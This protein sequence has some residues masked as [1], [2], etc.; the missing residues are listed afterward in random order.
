MGPITAAASVKASFPIVDF[1]GFRSGD[2]GEKRRVAR[3]IVDGCKGSGF[4]YLA[5]HG[6]SQSQLDGIFG[7]ARRLF[8]LPLDERMKL[9][10]PGLR[11]YRQYGFYAKPDSARMPDLMEHFVCQRELPP[12]DPDILAGNHM[13]G[14]NKWP[15]DLPGW[16]EDVLA[17]FRAVEKLSFDLLGAIAIALDVEEEYFLPFFRKPTSSMKVFHYP[18]QAPGTAAK[19]VGLG[20]HFDDGALTLL[21]QDEVGGLQVECP[22]G[23]INVSPIPGTFVINIGEIM[24]RWTN[25]L[26]VPTP[27]R[28]VNRFGR[29]RYSIPFFSSPD[30]DAMIGPVPTCIGLENPQKYPPRRAAFF[31][32]RAFRDANWKARHAARGAKLAQA[33]GQGAGPAASQPPAQS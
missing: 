7:A 13:H 15:A 33:A 24:A 22:S 12:D 16:R 10:G 5:G 17:Y 27:H 31:Q 6:I 29:E 21:L 9:G 8:D 3:S 11:G 18:P 23:W 1:A 19:Q 20:A 25:D 32:S 2:G 26:L 14:L 30:W 28:V 4:F